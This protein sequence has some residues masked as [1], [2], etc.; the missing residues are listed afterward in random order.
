MMKTKKSFLFSIL[1][2]VGS[3]AFNVV[4]AVAQDTVRAQ[5]PAVYQY[6]VE[7]FIGTTVPE[8]NDTLRFRNVGFF[9]PRGSKFSTASPSLARAGK[10][11]FSLSDIRIYNNPNGDENG[12][13]DST[14]LVVTVNFSPA[15]TVDYYDTLKVDV[16]GAVAPFILPLKGTGVQFLVSPLTEQ[17]LGYVP[18][19]HLATTEISL[20][21]K[22]ADASI[23]HTNFSSLVFSLA[24]ISQP[25]DDTLKLDIHF[26]P[27][28]QKG[29]TDTLEVTYG[30]ASQVY[31]VPLK[32]SGTLV[33]PY[34]DAL[35][36]QT[37][38]ID[39]VKTLD[40]EVVVAPDSGIVLSN[41][42]I[43][44]GL[45]FTVVQDA[46]WD[47]IT[48]GILH[49]SFTPKDTIPYNETLVLDGT[50]LTNPVYVP[51]NGGGSLQPYITA[52]HSV[53]RFGSVPVG[54]TVISDTITVSLIH[55]LSQLT[56]QSFSIADDDGI[57]EVVS[58]YRDATAPL[59]PYTVYVNLSF[60]PIDA[61]PYENY[62]IV[63]ADYATDYE[64]SL[65]GTGISSALRGA[66]Q[67]T[68]I[69]T[70]EAVA[71]TLS[72]KNGDITVSKASVG[73]TVKVYNLQGQLLKTQQVS[74]E[75]EVLKTAAWPK[76][77]YVVVVE[78][79]Q[80]EVLKEKVAL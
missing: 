32:G 43:T 35:Y 31:R 72:V 9:A 48:G 46:D 57:F 40:L 15:D 70:Q 49:I 73:S 18:V 58:V 50:G 79:D 33:T 45:R 53:V 5:A 37:I 64:I 22:D 1:L 7:K 13:G 8:V 2:I 39:S 78:S 52:D 69:S 24:G 61:E 74:A 20:I 65:S 6:G 66:T 26:I 75:V 80:Q 60:T 11:Q 42:V 44:P 71:T 76:G 3:L 25:A 68:A 56:D 54:T 19:W 30:D 77:I 47:S 41:P 14:F 10:S 16:G 67:A 34:P 21:A 27:R 12:D 28:E 63:K 36:F 55:H 62:L 17:N 29:Y 38:P 59:E 4:N 23:V 51:L